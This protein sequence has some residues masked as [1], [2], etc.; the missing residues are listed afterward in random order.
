MGPRRALH[1]FKAKELSNMTTTVKVKVLLR[2]SAHEGMPGEVIELDAKT[3]KSLVDEGAVDPH[4]DAVANPTLVRDDAGNLVDLE[5]E[6]QLAREKVKAA[7]S[8]KKL[9]QQQ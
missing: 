6:K 4:E 1:K 5:F 2:H 3:A 7:N 9:Q 8:A